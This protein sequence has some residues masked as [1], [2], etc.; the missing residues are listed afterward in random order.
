MP[1]TIRNIN[2]ETDLESFIEFYN[3]AHADYPEFKTLTIEIARQYLFDAPD[4]NVKG[5][6][7]ALDGSRIVGRGRVDIRAGT[8]SIIITVRLELRH[9]GIEDLLYDAIIE[10]LAAKNVKV[11]WANILSQF[12]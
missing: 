2:K 7:L 11:I 6:Y 1:I 12:T 3:L 8:G 5:N 4:F 9:T 10:H